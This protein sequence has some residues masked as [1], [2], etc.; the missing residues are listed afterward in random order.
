LDQLQ[1]ILGDDCHE[2]TAV[3]AIL[4]YNFDAEKALDYIFSKGISKLLT[5]VYLLIIKLNVNLNELIFFFVEN[6]KDSSRKK[7]AKKQGG[8]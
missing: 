5:F 8:S 2:P 4:K 1:S 7:T 3:D 6:K